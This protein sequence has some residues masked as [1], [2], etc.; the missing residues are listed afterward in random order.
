MQF[1]LFI[2]YYYFYIY[3]LLI[4][5]MKDVNECALQNVYCATGKDLGRSQ[6][7]TTRSIQTT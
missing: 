3:I 6:V 7:C 5:K 1:Y 2:Y 4:Q